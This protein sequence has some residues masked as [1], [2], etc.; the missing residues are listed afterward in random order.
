MISAV[1]DIWSKN[2]TAGEKKTQMRK[3]AFSIIICS[4]P[5]STVVWLFQFSFSDGDEVYEA[6]VVFFCNERQILF[7]PMCP[8]KLWDSQAT[9]SSISS[10]VDV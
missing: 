1:P 4:V 9:F 6:E 8:V 2:T 10:N 7:Q 5:T 3:M